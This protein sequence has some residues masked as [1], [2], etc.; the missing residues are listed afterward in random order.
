MSST[1]KITVVRRPEFEKDL[2]K[3]TKRYRTLPEDLTTM[4]ETSLPLLHILKMDNGG[5]EEISD[6]SLTRC[7]AFKVR[8]FACKA[9]K[10][11]GSRSGIRVTYLWYEDEM[12]AELV[13]IYYKGD[14]ENEDR[15]RLIE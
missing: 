7:R 9:F 5:I 11:K 13:E 10:G 14:K 2:K 3:L 8:R 1:K 6:V 12:R 4:V 15:T